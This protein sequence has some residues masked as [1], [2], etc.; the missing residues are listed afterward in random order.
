ML[1]MQEQIDAQGKEIELLTKNRQ[2]HYCLTHEE[3]R[4]FLHYHH[5]NEGTVLHA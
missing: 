2:E 1:Q 5:G 4:K 3:A